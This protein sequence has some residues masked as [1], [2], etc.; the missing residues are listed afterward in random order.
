MFL[1]DEAHKSS[2]TECSPVHVVSPSPV[3][4]VPEVHPSSEKTAS[5]KRSPGTAFRPGWEKLFTGSKASEPPAEKKKPYCPW[6]SRLPE[7][8]KTDWCHT[9]LSSAIACSSE[10]GLRPTWNIG[11]IICIN[12]TDLDDS[13]V[14]KVTGQY[15][16]DVKIISVCAKTGDIGQL[17]DV[18]KGKFSC[19]AGQ[20]AVGKSSM[21]NAL[22][23]EKIA[24]SG[25][26]SGNN[27]GKN[28]TTRATLY[29]L[30]DNTFIADTPGFGLLDVFDVEYDELDLYYNEYVELSQCCKYHRCK[31][32]NEPGCEVKKRVA[33]GSL[34]KDRYERYIQTY[35]EL[36][37]KKK[38]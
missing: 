31:H 4:W 12:K 10:L 2:P 15:G 11:C 21:I 34:N 14:Q 36:K 16:A 24:K 19:F 9:G 23:G 22:H 32:I 37:S 25:E 6:R 1:R 29:A 3:S 28:T 27:R 38:Y 33:E 20:S 7:C 8:V 17:I 35:N 26:L 5:E 18:L 30:D 13:F